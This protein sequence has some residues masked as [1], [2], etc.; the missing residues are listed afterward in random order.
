MATKTEVI[1]RKNPNYGQPGEPEMLDPETVETDDGLVPG[2]TGRDLTW[3]EFLDVGMATD[4][5]KTNAILANMPVVAEYGRKY[6]SNA[7]IEYADASTPGT[8][9]ATLM[10]AAKAAGLIDDQFLASFLTNWVSLYPA[11]VPQT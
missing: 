2:N 10:G 4:P 1:Y 7:G 6:V 5:T 9:L 8:R 3:D 11:I